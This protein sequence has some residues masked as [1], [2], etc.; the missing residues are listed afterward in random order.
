MLVL[1]AHSHIVHVDT[2][3]C[4]TCSC[5]CVIP[6]TY[7][8]KALGVN[9]ILHL[10]RLSSAVTVSVSMCVLK[11][12]VDLQ[13]VYC[14]LCVCLRIVHKQTTSV[15]ICMHTHTVHTCIVELGHGRSG[16]G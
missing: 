10:V 15:E 2:K 16:P 13:Y 6:R 3:V 11:I 12:V 4:V 5:Q 8:T 14:N 7:S 9:S 1:S